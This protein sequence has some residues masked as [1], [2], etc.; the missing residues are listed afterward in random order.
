MMQ[1]A[2]TIRDQYGSK[3]TL[4]TGAKNFVGLK[5]GLQF[6]IP[7]AKDGITMVVVK[8]NGNDLYDV[9]YGKIK[10]LE[11]VPI[12]T[13]ENIFSSELRSDFTEKTGLHTVIL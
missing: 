5:D 8:L 12:H 7:R 2:K 9:Q 4:V 11:F 1:I 6:T 3:F 13:S 10:N